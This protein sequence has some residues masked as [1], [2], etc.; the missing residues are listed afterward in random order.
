MGTAEASA[1]LSI[2]DGNIFVL[3]QEVLCECIAL[4]DNIRNVDIQWVIIHYDPCHPP[5]NG[6]SSIPGHHLL[7]DF[8]R[9]QFKFSFLQN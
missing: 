9:K 8:M 3:K 7:P 2:I 5:W 1:A 4:F 6:T